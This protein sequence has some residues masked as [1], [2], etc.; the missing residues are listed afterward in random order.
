MRYI[1]KFST[2]GAVQEALENSLLGKPYVAYVEDGQYIDWNSKDVPVLPYDEQYF[3]IEVLSLDPDS[4]YEPILDA[5]ESGISISIN[6][7]PWTEIAKYETQTLAVGDKVR[8]KKEAASHRGG[9]YF[10]ISFCRYAAYGNI[11]SMEYG[12]N[13]SGQTAV[14]AE[15]AFEWFFKGSHEGLVTAENLILPATTLK[16]SCYERMFDGCTNLTSAPVLP[17][18]RLAF[19]CYNGMFYGCTSLTTAPV[20]PARPS[21]SVNNC[22]SFMFRDCRNLNTITCLATNTSSMYYSNWVQGVSST[23]TF[24]KASSVT[25]P[26]GVSGIPDG[27]TVVDYVDPNN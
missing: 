12:D 7:G 14:R 8:F 21:G 11:E 26:T 3:T 1:Q 16:R 5:E 20:L 19:S 24:Y 22:Y 27:W 4:E 17:A 18:T 10:A 25:W 2:S 13:F 15:K 9:Q 6:G 23:G